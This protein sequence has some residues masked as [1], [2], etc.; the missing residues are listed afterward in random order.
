MTPPKDMFQKFILPLLLLVV[1]TT[2]SCK[3]SE[4]PSA[5]VISLQSG[6]EFTP[7]GA[8]VRTGGALSFGISARPGNVNLT[9][10]VIKKQMPD[11][12]VKVVLDSGMNSAG[13]QLRKIF[14]QNVE[15]TAKWIFQVMDRNRMLASTWVTIFKDPLSQ[16]GGIL[17]Y[18]Y[19]IMGYQGNLVTGQFL[20]CATGKTY[21]A[22]SAGMA[23]DSIDIATVFFMDDN[24][25]SPTFTSPG[26]S[27][28]G[29]LEYYPFISGWTTKLYTK[30]D[31]SVD[32]DPISPA[33][34][35]ACHN[36]SLLIVSYDNVWGK[37]K[38]KWAN[39]GDIIPF[40]TARGKLGLIRVLS[41][42]HDA[43]GTIS[44]SMKV[45]P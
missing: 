24:E 18:P 20:C 14:Y 42:D 9:N 43:T 45:Q 11:G 28:G 36:D 32:D 27:G 5:P 34:Y 17:E 13:F 35:E 12:S 2:G 21:L 8:V 37:K 16:W 44:F 31:I 41:C 3:K 38:F 15:D 40:L 1:L 30:W 29:I 26:E 7:D 25:P 22:D 10:L 4:D 23:Q 39:P 33:I 6:P 19:I